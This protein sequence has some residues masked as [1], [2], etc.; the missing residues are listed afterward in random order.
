MALVFLILLIFFS[1]VYIQKTKGKKQ[2]K[3]KQNFPEKWRNLL[4]EKVVFCRCK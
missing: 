3:T 2:E 4:Q 1:G